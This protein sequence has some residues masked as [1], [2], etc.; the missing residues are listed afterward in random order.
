[1]WGESRREREH[2]WEKDRARCKQ[3]SRAIRGRHREDYGGDADL[4][5]VL[6]GAAQEEASVGNDLCL[7]FGIAGFGLLVISARLNLISRRER[8]I[9][10]VYLN[11][12]RAWGLKTE[13]FARDSINNLTLVVGRR[14][15][16]RFGRRLT[17]AERDLIALRHDVEQLQIMAFAEHE[18]RFRA[19]GSTVLDEPS[20]IAFRME[21]D[22]G[23]AG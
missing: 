18:A 6:L 2:W 11:H 4:P 7:A 3:C 23:I 12:C 14:V 19:D 5:R 1:M 13:H 16:G 21:S 9:A 15:A 8:R 22:N 10:K 17:L 20:A